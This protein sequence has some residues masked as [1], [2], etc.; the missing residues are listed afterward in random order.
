MWLIALEE[1][2]PEVRVP[3]LPGDPDVGL[4]L[5]R[6]L[7]TIYDIMGYDELIDYTQPPPGTLPPTAAGWVEE[8][9]QRTGRR[10]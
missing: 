6:A 7:T 5:Q 1:R 2:L 4:D 8:Q 10:K 3:L 9:L